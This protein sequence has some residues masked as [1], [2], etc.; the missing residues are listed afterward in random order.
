[1]QI[2]SSNRVKEFAEVNTNL[3]EVKKMLDLVKQESL[4]LD[5][6]FLEPACGDG[7][8]LDQILNRKIKQLLKNFK[9]NQFEFEKF[10]IITV[11]SI[12]GI[13]IQK[14][15][16]LKTRE[17]LFQKLL[18]TY[19]ETFV[20]SCDQNFL[21]SVKFVVEKNII[22][23]DALL[24]RKPKSI[25]PILFS[26]WSLVKNKIK[27]REFTFNNL[28]NHEPYPEN[29]LFSDL[30]NEVWIPKPINDYPLSDIYN[31]HK[32]K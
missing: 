18:N 4:R 2:K 21:K 8:F 9:K 20:D 31:L 24:L 10:S 17:S 13:E 6:R 1:M 7:V 27:R 3:R 12:Y 19:Q 30:N 23:G 29:S 16:V 25:E 14:D 28:L 5:S 11:G 22:H 15:N 32:Q 26:E